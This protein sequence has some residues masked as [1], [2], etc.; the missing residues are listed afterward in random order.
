MEFEFDDRKSAANL[1]KHGI[2]FVSAQIL[3]PDPRR[4]ETTAMSLAEP[5]FQ[6]LGTID[7]KVWSACITYRGE[8]VRI[9]SVRRARDQEEEKYYG[10]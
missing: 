2:D 1:S 4:L 5:R 7:G 6:V 3:W 8:N 10:E 9:M